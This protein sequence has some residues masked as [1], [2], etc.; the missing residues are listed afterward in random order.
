M[1]IRIVG[2]VLI[3]L[4]CYLLGR[5]HSQT[6]IIAK[7]TEVVKHVAQQKSQIHSRPNA[8]R[9]ALLKLMYAEKL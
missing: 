6:Q 3:L 2:L 8:S 5:S 7:Q 4:L 1:I 9:D